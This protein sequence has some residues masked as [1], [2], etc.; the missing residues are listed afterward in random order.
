VFPVLNTNLFRISYHNNPIENTFEL[1]IRYG[2]P[3]QTKQIRIIQKFRWR[4]FALKMKP[5]FVAWLWTARRN[6]AERKYS[7]D[8]LEEFLAENT[9]ME[10]EEALEIFFK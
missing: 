7:P 3:T 2:A 4:F 8:R 9:D 5:K 1:D 10:L 6:M